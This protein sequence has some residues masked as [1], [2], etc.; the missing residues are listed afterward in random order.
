MSWNPFPVDYWASYEPAMGQTKL[1]TVLA[2]SSV[3]LDYVDNVQER[4]G[5]MFHER[6]YLHWYERFGCEGETFQQAFESVQ[7]IIDAYKEY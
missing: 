1:A 3:V 4:A 6:A 5:A 7:R 2:N